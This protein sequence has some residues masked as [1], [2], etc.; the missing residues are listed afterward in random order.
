LFTLRN[1][2]TIGYDKWGKCFAWKRQ[3]GH[4]RQGGERHE[5]F[6]WLWLYPVFRIQIVKIGK[7]W[8]IG[9]GS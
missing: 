5:A 9:D 3:S 8:R 7:T 6:I 2:F 4:T 1:Q